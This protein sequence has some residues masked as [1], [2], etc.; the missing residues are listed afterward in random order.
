MIK[1]EKAKKRYDVVY[2]KDKK[3][4]SNYCT[5]ERNPY[6]GDDGEVRGLENGYPLDQAFRIAEYYLEIER[7]KSELEH[8]GRLDRIKWQR[9]LYS[10]EFK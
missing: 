8:K 7:R 1:M 2:C 6:K 4:R 5:I 3:T 9:R 10:G